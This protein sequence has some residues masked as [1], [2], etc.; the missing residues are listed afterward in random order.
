MSHNS[1]AVLISGRGSNMLALQRAC[2]DGRVA[3]RIVLVLSNDPAA[4]GLALAREQGLRVEALERRGFPSRAAYE[5]ALGDRIEASGAEL[6]CLAGFMRRLGPG[7]V[8]RFRGRV[9]NIHPS[10]LPAFPGLDAQHQAWEYGARVSG[11][12]VHFV[13]QQLDHGPI[14]LQQVVEVDPRDSAESIAGRI[15]EREHDTYW[16]AVQLYFERRLE[17]E[18]RRVMIL[19]RGRSA[20]ARQSE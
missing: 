8:Q 17:L 6:I 10:L 9:L 18:G 4:A 20:D 14:I 19:P 2:A 11:C 3:A 5:Q 7:F 1:F 15:L 16:R 13:D 12:T